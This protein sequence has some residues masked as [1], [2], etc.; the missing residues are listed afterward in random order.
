MADITRSDSNFTFAFLD[1][2]FPSIT[3]I[4]VGKVVKLLFL[5]Y[6]LFADCKNK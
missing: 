3:R 2:N 4:G 6:F 5:F 1:K